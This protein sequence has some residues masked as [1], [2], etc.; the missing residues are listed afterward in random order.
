MFYDILKILSLISISWID[1]MIDKNKKK[2]PH[3]RTFYFHRS[4]KRGSVCD[5]DAFIYLAKWLEIDCW[6]TVKHEWTDGDRLLGLRLN[7]YLRVRDGLRKVP[8]RNCFAITY[9]S[10]HRKCNLVTPWN[11]YIYIYIFDILLIHYIIN[12]IKLLLIKINYV[13]ITWYFINTLLIKINRV[14]IWQ[15][16]MLAYI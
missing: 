14:K 10:S 4:R 12:K 13:K 11:H 16:L 5:S 9:S 8:S 3:P 1:S 2:C 15:I 7:Y 6:A